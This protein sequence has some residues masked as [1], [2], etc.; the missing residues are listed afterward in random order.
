MKRYCVVLCVTAFLAA[1]A[2]IALAADSHSA[3]IKALKD[4]EAQWNKDWEARDA[5]KIAS[6][7][8]K[9]A[10]LMAPGSA[11]AVGM[12]AIQGELKEM[13][14]DPALSLKFAPSVVEVAKSGDMAYTQGSYTMTVTDSASKKV[15]H[16]K[17]S[18]VTVYKKQGGAWKAVSDI[19]TSE[20]APG[21]M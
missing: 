2:A 13:V 15:I 5:A 6:H 16:D 19:A 12:E 21:S 9:D 20:G 18:Y 10:V 4:N 14:A 8:G 17:G 1:T 7:Y 11:P 3:D